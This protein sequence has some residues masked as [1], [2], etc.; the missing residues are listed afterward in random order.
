MAAGAGVSNW[1]DDSAP[2]TSSAAPSSQR[3]DGRAATRPPGGPGPVAPS[4]PAAPAA[5][6]T[7]GVVAEDAW[8]NDDNRD[9]A[10]SEYS[11]LRVQDA[12]GTERSYLR[13]DLTHV[14]TVDEAVLR[15]H[16]VDGSS[17]AGSVYAVPPDWDPLSLT[18]DDAPRPTGQPIAR[19]GSVREGEV[20][21]VDVSP[22][23]DGPGVYAFALAD[24]SEDRARFGSRAGGDPAEL[25]VRGRPGNTGAPW[26]VRGLW[27]SADELMARP[28]HGAAWDRLVSTARSEVGDAYLADQDSPHDVEVMAMALVAARTGDADLRD[29]AIDEVM[30]VIGTEDA[31]DPNCDFGDDEGARG[32]AIG[33][34]LAGYVVAADLVGLHPDDGAE[35]RRLADW[36]DT[37]RHRVNCPANGRG[38]RATIIEGHAG[39]G[40]NGSALEGG[41]RVAASVYLDDH[42]DLELAWADFRR[43]SG[44]RSV[45]SDID[46][47][48]GVEGGWAHDP[49][50]PV[51][52]NPKGATKDG[53]LI[54][55]A[56]INDMVRG[57]DFAWPPEYT[58]YP[59]EGIAGYLVQAQFLARAGYPAWE[60]ED[61]APL[62]AVQFLDRLAQETGDDRWW[63]HT[64]WAKHLVNH[65][66]EAG[67]SVPEGNPDGKNMG[68]TDWTHGTAAG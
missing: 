22:P 49:R 23:V 39:S 44:D 60:V 31:P 38:E 58:Q 2:E 5:T 50:E 56:I 26:Q 64:N 45:G 37:V 28:M 11:H 13:F 1:A 48:N 43:Y 17:D 61:R 6:V 68:W 42:E 63:D 15:L 54:D 62:R 10:Y 25:L 33:R 52:V 30:E 66:Y 40:S 24:G 14:E 53:H 51:A 19:L 16:V 8:V 35:G 18:W 47:G 36:L 67:L 34:N 29:R 7:M 57:G 32:L 12:E 55:G 20:V 3:P 41:A 4:A 27:I 46:I 21:E 9:R 65:V 59:W